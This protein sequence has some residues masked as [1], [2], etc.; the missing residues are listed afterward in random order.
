MAAAIWSCSTAQ[1]SDFP[2]ATFVRF[3]ANHGLL[4]VTNRP[5]W[6]TVKGG[7]ARRYVERLLASLG[8]VRIATPALSVAR[9]TTDH[10]TKVAVRSAHGTSLFDHVVLA[11]HSDQS[12]AILDDADRDE[13]ELLGAIR[14]QPN[15]AIL[16]TDASV[17]PQRPGA[18]AAWNYECAVGNDGNDG[19][20]A[21]GRNVHDLRT[22]TVRS[23]CITSS[24][25]CS[26][27]P[28]VDP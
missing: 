6:H 7:G 12:L 10:G 2:L 22:A 23:A 8:D 20:G 21:I 28:S 18:W 11:G 9:I 17:L 25:N 24:T 13:R 5:Q 19:G 16:H 1:M 14:Y 26:R 15:R 4:Q 3:C 27:F